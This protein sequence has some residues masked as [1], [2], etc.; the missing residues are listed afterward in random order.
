MSEPPEVTTLGSTVDEWTRAL[1]DSSGS[2]GGGAGAGVML[3]IAASL[4]SMAAGYTRPEAGGKAVRDGVVERARALRAVALRLADDDSSASRAFGAAFHLEEGP[5]REEAIGAASIDAARASAELGRHA[6]E[7]IDDLA[8]LAE[9]GNPAL[10]ADVV[11]AL[12]ALRAA[13][14]GARTNVSFDLASAKNSGLTSEE[15]RAEH[16][17]LWG[18]VGVFDGAIDRIDEHTRAVADRGR[19]SDTP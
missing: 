10:I 11:V 16:P 13:L 18:A 12:G 4:T 6:I 17:R 2:P 8:W 9:N 19:R 1:A 14:T 15:I 7:A 5:E 3:A